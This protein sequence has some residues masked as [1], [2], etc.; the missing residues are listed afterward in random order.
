MPQE[1]S[2]FPGCT[3][4]TT[5]QE[6][7]RSMLVYLHKLGY[8]LAELPDW[9]CCGTSSA[10]SLNAG[11]AFDLA[12]R[13]LS[14]APKG[15]PLLAACPNCLLR[16]SEARLK[17]AQS[18]EKRA[19][20]EELFQKPFDPDLRI[21][22]VFDLID[23]ASEEE[24]A[25]IVQ[26]PLSNLRFAAYYGCMLN[27]PV[28]LA[29]TRKYHGFLE[30]V[31]EKHG[32]APVPWSDGSLCCGTFLTVARPEVVTPMVD[33]IFT[34]AAKAGAQCIVTA[35]AMCHMNLEVRV[36][37]KNK[38]PVLHFSELLAIAAGSAGAD[39]WFSR[40]LIDPRPLFRSLN[41]L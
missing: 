23:R 35:C 33:H 13:N 38:I 22:H 5:A 1:I 32:A 24:I 18:P 11:L 26:K 3:L 20:Y 30:R 34:S 41:L 25:A 31:L 28:S 21:I 19:R 4:E 15:V 16:L 7:N 14:L 37:V 9:N 36:T 6:N 39:R 12:C 29:R 40:H 27:R 8:R 2:Y 17:L 10:H